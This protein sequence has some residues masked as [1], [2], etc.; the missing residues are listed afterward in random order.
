MPEDCQGH[1]NCVG[2]VPDDGEDILRRHDFGSRRDHVGQQ[3]LAANLVQH[4]GSARLQPRAF[5]GGKDGNGEGGG[6]LRHGVW[7]PTKLN[8]PRRQRHG[9]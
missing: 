9:A 2:F 7:M 6:G 8:S 4:F 5:T 3:R 1:A